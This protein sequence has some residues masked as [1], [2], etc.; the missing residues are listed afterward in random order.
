MGVK[1][2]GRALRIEAPDVFTFNVTIPEIK[3]LS[4]QARNC[5]R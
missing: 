4:T 2:A 5:C 1:V 3:S